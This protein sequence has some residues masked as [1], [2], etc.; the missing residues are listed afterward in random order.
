MPA[1]HRPR[2]G[3]RSGQSPPAPSEARANVNN[4]LMLRDFLI[5]GLG[6]GALPSFLADPA[7]ASGQL[8]RVLPEFVNEPRH[9]YAVYPTNRHLQPKVKA[10][11]DYLIEHLKVRW[12]MAEALTAPFQAFANKELP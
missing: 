12:P 4:S 6:I 3:R 7:I 9:I 2:P 5:A 11:V 8:Q 1:R 10:F